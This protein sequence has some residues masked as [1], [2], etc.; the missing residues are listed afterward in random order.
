VVHHDA[1]VKGA[2]GGSMLRETA[3]FGAEA[4]R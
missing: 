2:H 4:S 1:D 3:C